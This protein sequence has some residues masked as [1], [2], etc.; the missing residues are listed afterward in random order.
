MD[1]KRIIL[2]KTQPVPEG[3]YSGLPLVNLE[4]VKL[5]STDSNDFHDSQRLWA[6]RNVTMTIKGFIGMFCTLTGAMVT[7]IYT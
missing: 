5:Q 4:K 2:N 7:Q 6:R 1:L 3:P